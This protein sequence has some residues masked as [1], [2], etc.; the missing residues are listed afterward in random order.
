MR[1]LK[2]LF[3]VVATSGVISSLLSLLFVSFV[4]GAI[5][6]DAW[7]YSAFYLTCYT[8]LV[9]AGLYVNKRLP[10]F[11]RGQIG[12]Q[13]ALILF[14]CLVLFATPITFLAVLLVGATVYLAS[15]LTHWLS[16]N[17]VRYLILS[18]LI[19][20]ILGSIWTVTTAPYYAEG[21]VVLTWLI[22]AMINLV[23]CLGFYFISKL[24]VT[25]PVIQK[26]KN[27]FLTSIGLITLGAVVSFFSM[28][29]MIYKEG[30][31]TTLLVRDNSWNKA[32][33]Y[34]DPEPQELT[35]NHVSP[36]ITK[37]KFVE[38]LLNHEKHSIS[39]KAT[40]FFLTN[41]Q[42]WAEQF[43]TDLLQEASANKFTGKTDSMKFAQREAMTRAMFLLEIQ[44]KI[45]NFITRSEQK[46]LT[47]W[48]ENIARRIFQPEWVDYL[49]AVP[50]KDDPDG[51]YLN[52]EVGAGTLAVLQHVVKD[53]A[54][55]QKITKFLAEKSAGFSK[56]FRNPDDAIGYQ[57]VWIENAFAMHLY[58]GKSNESLEGMKL[59]LDW[60]MVQLPQ[61]I[62]PLG[63][64]LP[65]ELK[66]ITSLAVGA[67]YLRDKNARWL[68]EQHLK[69]IIQEKGRFPSEMFA[70]WLWDET[71]KLEKPNEKSVVIN[72]PTGYAFRP[73]PIAPDKVVLRSTDK[74]ATNEA[75]FLL[76]NLR[77]IGWHRYPA[78][79]TAISL[80]FDGYSIV[81]EDIIKKSHDWL[82]KGRAQHRDKKIDRLRLNGL[83]IARDGLDAWIGGITGV[84][85]SWRQDVPR[86]SKVLHSQSTAMYEAVTI[87]LENWAGTSHTRTYLLSKERQVLVIDQMT[88][89]RE[90]LAKQ[91]TWHVQPDMKQLSSNLY[92]N[93]K[94]VVSLSRN[95]KNQSKVFQK[96][97]EEKP[98]YGYFTSDKYIGIDLTGL[99]SET[100]VTAFSSKS[101]R[102][103]E[104]IN[105]S[106][107][108]SNYQKVF[109]YKTNDGQRFLALTT[110]HQWLLADSL[111]E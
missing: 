105:V 90:S 84:Y 91:I 16:P 88:S 61:N 22:F 32:I 81:G 108:Y 74:N 2:P 7:E 66:P 87:E 52:Q 48:F 100:V 28:Y 15:A 53:E 41:D 5:G 79:N 47:T 76:A 110:Q 101:E 64:G 6:I 72:G 68:L 10:L 89:D 94:Y 8:L 104:I 95:I 29:Y 80:L 71:V 31:P 40:L 44:N 62:V 63:Y 9:S 86:T 103:T 106:D 78:T 59:A 14:S 27:T 45:P 21:F 49:Y 12:A 42:I 83:Q 92:E 85:S 67:F 77:N 11:S 65:Y 4:S 109:S 19:T 93:D 58:T 25:E 55:Q 99:S 107:S 35:H 37:E 50:F 111:S 57:N 69:K 51:P 33:S 23:T 39:Q 13:L 20:A 70:F 97:I 24:F 30:E 43:R 82:P 17:F 54:L 46:L 98:A 34:I 60:L 3:F 75:A 26:S 18:T 56:N 73:G 38:Y 96:Q 36:E 1:V 102:I